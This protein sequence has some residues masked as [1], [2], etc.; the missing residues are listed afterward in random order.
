MPR[1]LC[2]TKPS[3]DKMVNILQT[4]RWNEFHWPKSFIFDWNF[5]KLCP[6]GSN[7]EYVNNCT[8][9]KN[10]EKCIYLFNFL[11]KNSSPKGLSDRWWKNLDYGI[12]RIE[13][14]LVTSTLHNQLELMVV[15]L[16]KQLWLKHIVV[17]NVKGVTIATWKNNSHTE[18][19]L[20]RV[21]QSANM[22]TRI[23]GPFLLT[24][25]NFNPSMDK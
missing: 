10:D 1:H 11:L 12:T 25:I 6:N 24:R 13:G 22:K 5:N 8:V 4:T 18:I 14:S 3:P 16:V 17:L 7:L 2:I 21:K 15:V 23:L 19:Y 20:A 9:S